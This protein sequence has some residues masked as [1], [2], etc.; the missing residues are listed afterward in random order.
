MKLTALYKSFTNSERTSG[1]VLICCTIVSLTT[2]NLF[3]A[4]LRLW[5]TE[6]AGQPITHWINDGL[7][8]IF[9]LLIGLELEREV[10]KGELSTLKKALL[11]AFAALGGMITPALIYFLINNGNESLSGIGI[12]TATDIA[13]ALAVLSL[14]GKRV[15]LSLK[16][17]V[18]AFAVMDDLGA[19]III[20]IFYTSTLNFQALALAFGILSILFLFNRLKINAAWPYLVGGTAMWF[21]MLN[22][23]IHATITGVL[24]AFAIPF[25]DG[26]EHTL[27]YRLQKF[28]HRPVTFIILPLFA[29]ANTSITINYEV[30]QQFGNAVSMGIL[31]GLC[32]GKPIGIFTF[33]YATV[34][35]RLAVLSQDITW[36]HIFGAGLLGG[37]GFT[38]SIFISLLAF[39]DETLVV[40]AKISILVASLLSGVVGF[41]YLKSVLYKTR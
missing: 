39:H 31:V 38:M 35:L 19:I 3:P 13:F 20:A 24:V 18:T 32:I 15:P 10:Y 7:M 2:T 17:F 26:S 16:I 6:L 27:S 22:S 41:F 1:V 34:K 29:L 25:G 12:P 37:V 8:T 5:Q 40:H 9:F 28:L 36:K 30:Y 4:Y 21:C 33:S 11:P 14:L 23:G